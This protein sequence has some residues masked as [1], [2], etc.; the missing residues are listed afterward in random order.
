M[1]LKIL[2]Y[3]VLG[4]VCLLVVAGL[5]ATPFVIKARSQADKMY[6]KYASYTNEVFSERYDLEPFPVKPEYRTLHP[7][8]FLKLFKISVDSR[9]GGRL[10]RVNSLDATMFLFMKMYTLMIRPD[11]RFNLPVLS[12]DFIFAGGK[13][14]YIIEVIDPA[15]IDD[16]NKKKY[17]KKMAAWMPE[18]E[19][20]EESPVAVRDWYKKYIT[21]FSI[22]INA[23]KD[24]DE[25]LFDI[26]KSYLN[27]YLDMVDNA[28]T[29]SREKSKKIKEGLEGYV[30]TLLSEGGPA[31][32][33]F[34]QM[35]GIEG[36]REYV[37]TVMFGLE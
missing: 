5:I 22:H 9:S 11:Y 16:E 1:V 12:V 33:V 8:K 21:D 7:W 31:V 19:K 29:L 10:K 23:T 36:Q 15:K 3:I 4:V 25:L 30:D 26:Y 24:D 34:E 18:I 27:A 35:L 13:R 2:K 14:V 20:F 17:Y 28:E 6:E 32:E 37:R